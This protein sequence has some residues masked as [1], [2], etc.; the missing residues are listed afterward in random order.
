VD[1]GR[2][3]LQCRGNRVRIHFF[4]CIFFIT[5]LLVI[6]S[7]PFLPSFN[8]SAQRRGR[9]ESSGGIVDDGRQELECR[10]NRVRIHFFSCL[11][12]VTYLLVIS[13][14]P[15][16]PSFNPPTQR[17]GREESSGGIA[18][19]GRREVQCRG[20]RV[21]FL[22]FIYP[23]FVIIFLRH[24]ISAFFPFLQSLR[25]ASTKRRGQRGNRGRRAA[26]KYTDA[27]IG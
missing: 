22:F 3:E 23:F 10:Q 24:L 7:L 9:E 6:S 21:S 18:Y 26:G 12:F 11:F 20:N 14:L 15:F 16:L 4:L 19:S 27:G 25:T 17:R 8:P 13:S 5:Y 1:G 2:R